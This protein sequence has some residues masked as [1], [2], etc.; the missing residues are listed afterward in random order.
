MIITNE[1]YLKQKCEPCSSVEEGEEIAA[2]LL[3]E[4]ASSGTGIGLAAN[5]IGINK[6]VCVI[7]I[8]TSNN[9]EP[10]IL[11]NPEIIETS[12]DKFAFIEGCLSFPKQQVTTQR[13]KWVKVKA[14]NH[15]STLYFTI[16]HDNSEEGFDKGK[17]LN[18]AYETACVQHEIDHLD[19]ITM[20]DRKLEK[21]TLQRK[22]PKIGR[23]SK[24]LI[25]KGSETKTIKYKKFEK[26][27]EDGW[28]LAEV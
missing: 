28:V 5:Q 11:V 14:D 20:F 25:K 24:V 10:I 17:Y 23:N 16:Y 27:S 6:R 22:N 18:Y 9:K 26:M 7:N 21:V 3:T 1:E 19:G 12:K 8:P 15:T 13:Y 4:L 2:K